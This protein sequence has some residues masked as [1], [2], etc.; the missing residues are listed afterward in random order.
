MNWRTL[1]LSIGM[2]GG[3]VIVIELPASGLTE[4]ASR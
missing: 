2:L 1:L 3:S 4:V